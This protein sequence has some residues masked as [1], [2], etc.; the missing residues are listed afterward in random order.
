MTLPVLLS[1]DDDPEVQSALEF[2]LQQAFADRCSIVTA[3]SGAAALAMI[4]R[5]VEDEVPIAL[6]LADQRMPGMS[7]V[8]LL[9]RAKALCP[10]AKRV[11]LT[12]FADT[13]AAIKAINQAQL[14]HYLVKPWDPPERLLYPV[15]TDLLDEWQASHRPRFEGVTVVG[16]RWSADVHRIKGFLAGNLVPY[17]WL[18][19]ESSAE[20]RRIEARA[21]AGPMPIVVLS[22]RS[23]LRVPTNAEI[24][25]R[26]GLHTTGE[27]SFYDLVVVGGGPAALA[28]AVYGAS[29]GLRTVIVERG[30]PGGQAATSSRI[31][32]YLGF[33]SGL[34]GADLAQRA[35]AQARR[36]G[37]EIL[38]AREAVTAR[39]EGRYRVATLSDGQELS[40]HAMLIATGMSVRIPPIRGIER[41][42]GAGVYYG[43]ATTEAICCRG[44]EVY[45]VGAGN[46]A[47]QGAICLAAYAS[48]VH[49]LVRGDSLS[50]T[51]SQY[52]IDRIAD[53]PNIE[54]HLQ[55]E[56]AEARGERRLE[57]IEVVD[58]E[59]GV[60][61][62]KDASTLFLFIGATPRT[63]WL[64]GLVARDDD[65]FV[66]T[67]PDLPREDRALR[68]AHVDREPFLL[69]SSVRGI[70]AAGD[71][72]HG[73]VKRIATAVGEGSM[74]IQ[75][76]H[77]YLKEL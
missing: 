10:D 12:G 30:A 68:R 66:L 64:D 72:R 51:M 46:S 58:L 65:G 16:H 70:F 56:V 32:N 7:G 75:F 71:V 34:S 52:L 4:E 67:G 1:I 48:K 50:H 47:G 33:P 44:E 17:R 18:D 25:E 19:P 53:T 37:V 3:S 9:T 40:C 29:E 23:L 26:V 60:R 59:S 15:L 13:D 11:L 31:E 49:V 38:T 24:A 14:H 27:R 39:A 35:V 76:V 8:E 43:A 55:H 22:D 2:D 41:L 73:S 77:Q 57:A 54:V 36:F 6:L 21:G 61:A 42:L 69:E 63:E 62:S 45:V 74:A 5:F 20:A 28:A